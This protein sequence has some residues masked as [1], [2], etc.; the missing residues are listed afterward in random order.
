MR[1]VP[2]AALLAILALAGCGKKA[3]QLVAPPPPPPSVTGVFPVARSTRVPYDTEIYVEF[4][5]ALDTTTV[6]TDNIFLKLDTQRYAFEPRYDAARRRLTVVPLAPL[7]LRRTYT[8][9]ITKRVRTA[10]GR[11]LGDP[12]FWQFTTTSLRRLEHPSP[13]DA[14]THESPF[15]ALVWDSTEAEAGLVQY[16]VWE[17]LDS[18]TVAARGADG[19]SLYEWW[20]L[21]RSRT[22]LSARRFWAVRALNRDTGETA[23]SPVWRYDVVPPGL[24]VDTVWVPCLDFGYFTPSSTGGRSVCRGGPWSGPGYNNGLWWRIPQRTGGWRLAGQDLLLAYS[25]FGGT[26][27]PGVSLFPT[28]GAFDPC[29]VTLQSPAPT[30]AEAAS[31]L[32]VGTRDVLRYRSDYFAAHL[33]ASARYHRVT[34]YTIVS[35]NW[36]VSSAT[37][38]VDT[39]RGTL[40]LFAY[41]LPPAVIEANE[42]LEAESSARREA[43]RLR[44]T[45]L[46]RPAPEPRARIG[47]RRAGFTAH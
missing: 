18:A 9:E 1:R 32:R 15:A 40:Q 5:E 22:P 19:R 14:A 11:A 46:A 28:S 20:Y 8:I 47:E 10:S 29:R 16:T 34:G 13:G 4:G 43:D 37:T 3:E 23:D 26:Q 36:L 38:G 21:S 42:R 25:F 45:A 30:A 6:N 31:G 39:T 27:L 12:F 7:R 24:P 44:G 33:E 17:G 41:R 2:L 35:T